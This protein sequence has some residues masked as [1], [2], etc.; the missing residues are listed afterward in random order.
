MSTQSSGYALLAIDKLKL[1][2]PQQQIKSLEMREDMDNA[3]TSGDVVG[4]L[5]FEQ[6]LRPVFCFNDDLSVLNPAPLKRRVC[7]LLQAKNDLFGIL[8]DHA[9]LLNDAVIHPQPFAECMATAD[10]PLQS[11]AII[12][13]DITSI[14]SADLLA[15]LLPIKQANETTGIIDYV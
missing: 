8:C 7:I 11:L 1:L 10:S 5:E 6:R 12:D 4:Y 3:E 15:E 9:E 14:S 13:N 2:I